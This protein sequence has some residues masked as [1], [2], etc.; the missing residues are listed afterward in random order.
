MLNDSRV[1]PAA[2]NNLS[3][4]KHNKLEVLPLT[5][6]LLEVR[7][8]IVEQIN[9]LTEEVKMSVAKE[10]W[11]QLAEVTVSRLIMFFKGEVIIII[12][13]TNFSDDQIETTSTMKRFSSR[14]QMNSKFANG[15][16][17][18]SINNFIIFL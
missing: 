10:K 8:F 1:T 7:T 12:I 9:V 3:A 6:D 14:C 11:R 5:E 16:Y 18:N 17:I 4:K 15:M 2:L 13:V